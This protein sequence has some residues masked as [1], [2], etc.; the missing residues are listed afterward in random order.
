MKTILRDG[1]EH[2]W[3]VKE[4][5]A[6]YRYRQHSRGGLVAWRPEVS[7]QDLGWC[8]PGH[9]GC[10]FWSKSICSGQKL[11]SLDSLQIRSLSALLGDLA[12]NVSYFIW[13][14]KARL[15]GHLVKSLAGCLEAELRVLAPY[16][17][18]RM[19]VQC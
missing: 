6:R 12:W 8:L 13:G 16:T 2:G 3:V 14:L 5:E 4:E 7:D 10:C 9:V 17:C 11:E 19:G 1:Q 18:S 15:D